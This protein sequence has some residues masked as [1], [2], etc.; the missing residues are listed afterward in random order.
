MTE[1]QPPSNRPRSSEQASE[2]LHGVNFGPQ[3]LRPEPARIL[4]TLI[5]LVNDTTPSTRAIASAEIERFVHSP[6]TDLHAE[7]FPAIPTLTQAI[8]AS[9]TF[10][11]LSELLYVA[12]EV[13]KAASGP[14]STCLS[15]AFQKQRR[16]SLERLAGAIVGKLYEPH[17]ELPPVII[18]R[19]LVALSR[20]GSI[21]API[22]YPLLEAAIRVYPKDA[23]VAR[24]CDSLRSCAALHQEEKGAGQSKVMASAWFRLRGL[25]G[26]TRDEQIRADSVATLAGAL[27]DPPALPPPIDPGGAALMVHHEGR[28]RQ[29]ISALGHLGARMSDDTPYIDSLHT[30]IALTGCLNSPLHDLDAVRALRSLGRA[31]APAIP[32]LLTVGASPRFAE[33][34]RGTA[35]ELLGH[36]FSRLPREQFGMNG[37]LGERFLQLAGDI[38]HGK[39]PLLAQRT[40]Q[41]IIPLGSRGR[42]LIPAVERALRQALETTPIPDD[43][44]DAALEP[45]T[46]VAIE[47][48]A[49]LDPSANAAAD[50]IERVFASRR[51]PD[52]IRHQLI[53]AVGELAEQEEIGLSV[54][55][56]VLARMIATPTLPGYLI[57]ELYAT[58]E[59][60]EETFRIH[61]AELPL[62]TT[63]LLCAPN[64]SLRSK[65]I[66]LRKIGEV[67]N[68]LAPKVTEML[69]KSYPEIAPHARLD[70]IALETLRRL[71]RSS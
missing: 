51:T 35:L 62:T 59:R 11:I 66:K 55:D 30:A 39:N 60:I 71:A 4:K 56:A 17:A 33:E 21:S 63:A 68:T 50:A 43:P 16:T 37:S 18:D 6:S 49:A 7:V 19:A 44:A 14:W 52:D 25:V 36:L 54:A 31:A 48:L 28:L 23:T 5:R 12:G 26:K 53:L 13:S 8:Q 10:P 29:A 47:A 42:E 34:T 27:F 38:L 69:V 15:G 3:S 58:T 40:L 65:E 24:A 32:A 61:P 20:F 46:F 64:L 9:S 41:G 45:I 22:A 67:S 70:D 57:D 2:D 1:R